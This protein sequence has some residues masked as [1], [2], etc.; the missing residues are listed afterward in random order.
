MEKW[1]SLKIKVKEY[2]QMFCRRK[3]IKGKN[4]RSILEERLQSLETKIDVNEFNAEI[5]NDYLKVKTKLEKIYQNESKGAGIRARVKWIEQGERSTKYFLGLEKSRVRKKEIKQLKSQNG[6]RTIRKQEEI[7]KEVR[8]F[9]SQLYDNEPKNVEEMRNYVFTQNVNQL[10]EEDKETCDGLLTVDECKQAIFNM[11]KNKSPGCDGISIEFYQ[12][13]WPKIKDILVSALNDCYVTGMMSNTQK[14]GLITLLFKKGDSQCLN[15]WRPITLLNCDYKI[16]AFILASRLQ[17]VIASI[18]SE[19]QTGYI[20]G[21]LSFTNVRLVKDVFQYFTN[22]NET[23]A[24]ML[25]DFTKAFDV[26]DTKFLGF[27]LEKFNFG[28]S[29]R[30]WVSVLYNDITSCALVNGWISEP[31]HIKRGVRQGCPLSALLF[32]LAVEF[33]AS[34]IRS[35]NCIKPFVIPK[36]S[37]NLKLVQ[38]AD[39]TLFVV[40]N[41][42]SLK[43][44]IHELNIFGKVAGPKLNKNKTVTIWI[45]DFRKRWN[46]LP[47]NLTWAEKPIKYLGHFIFTNNTEALEIEWI[48]KLKKLRSTLE[49][50]KKRNLSLFGRV[51]VLKSLALSQII[52]LIIVDSIPK[53]ILKT[54]NRMIYQFIWGSKTERVKRSILTEDYVN[55][56]IKMFDVEKK[57]LSYR[58]KWL[59]RLLNNSEGIWKDMAHFW[60]QQLGGIKLLLNCHYNDGILSSINEKKIPIFYGEIL[61][62]WMGIRSHAN[63]KCK[64]AVKNN[65]EQILWHNQ[66]ITYNQRSFYYGYWYDS[67]IVYVKDIIENDCLMSMNSISSKIIPHRR[68]CHL[69]FDY[70]K[71]MKA[72]PQIWIRKLENKSIKISQENC[73]QEIRI[74]SIF[75]RKRNCAIF[76][77]SSKDFYNIIRLNSRPPF[78]NPCCLFWENKVNNEVDWSKVFKRHLVI[79]KDNKLR[80][81]GFKLLYNLLPVKKNLLKWRLAYDSYCSH[82]NEE[83][84]VIHAFITCKLNRFFFKHVKFIIGKIF[85]ASIEFDT[86]L[87]FKSEID[88]FDLIIKIALWCIYVSILERNKTGKD[89]RKI[90]LNFLFA[91]EIEKRIEIN[92]ARNKEIHQLPREVLYYL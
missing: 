84:D 8:K 4:I 48:S 19:T 65:F 16:I 22:Q 91:R 90:S 60:F 63:T 14:R 5:E 7:I 37:T 21:R 33:M 61:Y 20:K 36:N 17:K 92:D 58:L 55:G 44:I 49:C 40:R 75:I 3:S 45:G 80:Q 52:H 13:F 85:G 1:E 88:D 43:E 56:G 64:I 28:S 46:L 86:T 32:V 53:D 34:R 74:P 31:F 79:I 29:F 54:L 76:D 78:T 77:L 41:E 73:D 68:K 59:G 12:T 39:D 81:F 69:I 89:R 35:N 51:T 66:N 24:V 2:T 72:L 30:S 47:Y 87:L 6:K 38:Y 11:A 67:G 70:M 83:E 25:A 62:A 82:C 71:L 26:L 57:M 10:S 50:W 42:S 18:V 15:N 27:C 9:Y 23:G